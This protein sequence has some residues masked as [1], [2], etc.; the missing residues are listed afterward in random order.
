MH[1][2]H[3]ANWASFRAPLNREPGLRKSFEH[4]F[5][6]TSPTR[7]PMEHFPPSAWLLKRGPAMNSVHPACAPPMHHLCT[8]QAENCRAIRISRQAVHH[9]CT[10]QAENCRAIRISRQAVNHLCSTQAE[11]CRAIRIPVRPCRVPPTYH[12]RT[13][14]RVPRALGFFLSQG[15]G[16]CCRCCCCRCSRCRAAAAVAPAV[17][18]PLLPMA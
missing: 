1:S 7:P 8:T 2:V 14:K 5:L 15:R 12:L 18:P 3:L 11:N 10:T 4:C 6:S 9:L 13:R 17:V 16:C